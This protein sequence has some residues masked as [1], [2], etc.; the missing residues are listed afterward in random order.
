MNRVLSAINSEPS[1]D[2]PGRLLLGGCRIGWPNY[3]APLVDRIAS[4]QLHANAHI[5]AH[6]CF[7]VRVERLANMLCVELSARRGREF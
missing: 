7:K 1:S 3:F 5:A 2:G 6:G 4:N